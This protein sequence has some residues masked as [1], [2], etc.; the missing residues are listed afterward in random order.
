MPSLLIKYGDLLGSDAEEGGAFRGHC[1]SCS[2]LYST[3]LY[4]TFTLEL[5]YSTLLYP[6]FTLL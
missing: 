3:L 5:L 6:T 1:T 2:L 4:P